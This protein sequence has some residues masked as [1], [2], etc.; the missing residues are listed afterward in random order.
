MTDF[1]KGGTVAVGGG[2]KDPVVRLEI[3]IDFA[4]T[5]Q[6]AAASPHPLFNV[7]A[8]CRC[9]GMGYQVI[10][11]EGAVGTFDLGDG[12]LATQYVSNG[13][14]NSVGRGISAIT[15]AKVYAAADT[16]DLTLD[17]DLDAAKIKFVALLE[18]YT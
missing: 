10:T 18:D 12:A 14:A 3:T 17:N 13:N 11:A 9:L 6:T 16:L 5:P 15:A 8:G 2:S 7:P 4:A 1:T